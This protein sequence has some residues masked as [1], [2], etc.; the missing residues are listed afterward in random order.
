[1]TDKDLAIRKIQGV[2]GM[3]RIGNVQGF[4]VCNMKATEK[5]LE[6]ALQLLRKEGA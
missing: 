5:K 6:E 4:E 3:V 1:M 2:L